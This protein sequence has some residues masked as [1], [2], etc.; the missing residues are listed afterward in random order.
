MAEKKRTGKHRSRRDVTLDNIEF[1]T[2]RSADELSDVQLVLDEMLDVLHE[3]RD[4]LA[5]RPRPG[6]RR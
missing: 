4:L 5:A 6:T 2:L 3:I 1:G